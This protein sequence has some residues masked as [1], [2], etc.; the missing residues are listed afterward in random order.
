MKHKK[1]FFRRHSL[2]VSVA[3]CS[4]VLITVPL[5]ASLLI[6]RPQRHT[7]SSLLRMAFESEAPGE[8][9]L[10]G[11]WVLPRSKIRIHMNMEGTGQGSEIRTAKGNLTMTFLV[12]VDGVQVEMDAEMRMLDQTI[13]V[14]L[15][16]LAVPEEAKELMKEAEAYLFQWIRIPLPDEDEL[17]SAVFLDSVIEQLHAKNIHV[18]REQL[19]AFFDL[20][21]DEAFILEEQPYEGG[22]SYTLTLDP[23]LEEKNDLEELR[24]RA[25]MDITN[26][27]LLQFYRAYLFLKIRDDAEEWQVG[28]A[29]ATVQLEERVGIAPVRVQH[30]ARAID[31]EMLL[32]P[33]D[34]GVTELGNGLYLVLTPEKILFFDAR[35]QT[36]LRT[37]PRVSP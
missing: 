16:R 19:V 8:I 17:Q 15:T 31:L 2:L 27:G 29:T 24:L 34:Y 21:I 23:A 20:F 12:N 11:E 22:R 9:R 35:E 30:P 3:V 25:K 33:E 5:T 4:L 36:I 13:Y 26:R 18:T 1:N 10:T 6:T 32:M 14:R 7:P 28:G 37:Y